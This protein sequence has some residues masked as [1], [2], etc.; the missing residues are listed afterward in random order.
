MTLMFNWLAVACWIASSGFWMWAAQVK[1]QTFVPGTPIESKPFNDY[2][3]K[4]AHRNT[5][6]AV[7]SGVAALCSAIALASQVAA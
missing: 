3:K 1:I 7:V 6:A 4:S 2:F 5:I